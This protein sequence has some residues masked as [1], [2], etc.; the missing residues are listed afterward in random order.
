GARRRQWHFAHTASRRTRTMISSEPTGIYSAKFRPWDPKSYL[1][2]GYPDDKHFG[3]ASTERCCKRGS[4][5]WIGRHWRNDVAVLACDSGGGYCRHVEGIYES[6]TARMGGA[7]SL[8]QHLC[9]DANRRAARMVVAAV[10]HSVRQYRDR[11]CAC[12]RHRE[13]LWAER[14]VR[15]CAALSP[16]HRRLSDPWLRELPVPEA[17]SRG[18]GLARNPETGYRFGAEASTGCPLR[19][20][21][22]SV[23]ASARLCYFGLH[24]LRDTKPSFS[25]CVLL[26][27]RV[28]NHA[29]K[30][31]ALQ[32]KGSKI[33]AA[34]VNAVWYIS[35]TKSL[36]GRS[37]HDASW[38][39]F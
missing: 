9:D 39:S 15:S 17:C 22:K 11:D 29:G 20:F 37:L 2:G 16:E 6:R 24:P 34:F 14:R 7:C 23:C 10:L 1:L 13:G 30:M 4:W 5:W 31:P 18:C 21:A 32:N 33:K 8:L 25:F 27:S 35:P 36:D 12:H 26:T 19:R 28:R 3:P 38:P